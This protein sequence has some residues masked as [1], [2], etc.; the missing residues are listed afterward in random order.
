MDS[1]EFVPISLR[2]SAALCAVL[3]GLAACDR[4]V[5]LVG[6]TDEDQ[7]SVATE[8]E[9]MAL[10]DSNI[11]QLRAKYPD[12]S[13]VRL[14]ARQYETVKDDFQAVA[15]NLR[16]TIIRAKEE[17]IS[18]WRQDGGEPTTI[19]DDRPTLVE[20]VRDEVQLQPH[21]LR[22]LQWRFAELSQILLSQPGYASQPMIKMHILNTLR[23]VSRYCSHLDFNSPEMLR[24][25][26]DLVRMFE[27]FEAEYGIK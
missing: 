23:D 9:R 2:S 17:A 20:T 3:F 15:R 6:K 11:T 5:F 8:T 18:K 1:K 10:V 26:N 4:G 25:Q 14:N 12:L 24:F 21:D 19:T 22:N 16:D 27:S 7:L 13:E